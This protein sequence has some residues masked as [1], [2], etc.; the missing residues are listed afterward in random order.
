MADDAELSAILRGLGSPTDLGPGTDDVSVVM[1]DH[2][3]ERL[4]ATIEAEAAHRAAYPS[5]GA[6]TGASAGASTDELAGRRQART[7]SRRSHSRRWATGL[8]AASAVVLAGVVAVSLTRT[9]EPLPLAASAAAL[10]DSP[11]QLQGAGL[12]VP[13][14][15]VITH[16]DTDYSVVGIGDQVTNLVQQAGLGLSD[17]SLAAPKLAGAAAAAP[18]EQS[19][20]ADAS[21]VVFTGLDGLALPQL[22]GAPLQRLRDCV[23]KLAHSDTA[24][25]LVI[26]LST[27][28]GQPAGIVVQQAQ[29][30]SL[31]VVNVVDVDCS[32]AMM[33]EIPTDAQPGM[34]PRLIP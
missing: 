25:A 6:S 14:A 11:A 3:W 10:A 30:G 21:S 5:T 17:I 20:P 12:F 9:S 7:D 33:V 26:D 22:V 15:K 29:N 19:A 24:S 18:A 4:Q 8:V 32:I 1:P 31:M 27:Y 28:D 13:P 34:A 2:V 23:T 16:T